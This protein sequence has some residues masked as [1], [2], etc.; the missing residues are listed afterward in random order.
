[1]LPHRK[2]ILEENV[3]VTLLEHSD[4]DKFDKNTV[5]PSAAPFPFTSSA[6]SNSISEKEKLQREKGFSE[7]D[8]KSG[9]R[10]V[11]N[12]LD[13]LYLSVFLSFVCL[14]Y[15]KFYPKSCFLYLVLVDSLL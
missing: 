8:S 11:C 7:R 12:Y 10:Q 5:F 2:F 13:N 4:I 14:M 15:A 6:S 3:A 1:M 9:I